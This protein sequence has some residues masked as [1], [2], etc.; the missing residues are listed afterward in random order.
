[1]ANPTPT[2]WQAATRL[3]L[4]SFL[5]VFAALTPAGAAEAGVVTGS[6]SN[7]VT[8]N[9]LEGA[10]VEIPKLGASALT[11]ATG[12]Y[13]L[14]GVP[15]GT[16]EVVASYIGLDP[17]RATVTVDAGR[18]ATR[19]FDLSSGVYQ[20]DTFKV[21]GEREGNA[22]AL[23]A[24]KNAPNVKNIVSID[25]Y[26][27]LPNMNA[28]EL[29]IL[30]P[31]VAGTVNDEGNYNGMNI[32][33][34]AAN[35]NTITVDGALL[36]SQGGSARA[37]RIHTITGSMFES[38]E[39]TKG[40]TPDKGA[41]SL[42]GTI[43]LKSRSP[44]NQKEKRRLT[45]NLSTRIA[46]SFTEQIPMRERHRA[47]P[48]LNAA[49]QE[50]F[51]VLGEER[52]LGVAVN[53]F[54]IEQAVGNFGTTRNFQTTSTQ[55][56]YLWDYGTEDNYNNRKQSSVNAKIDYRLSA[57]T[58][59]SLNTIYNDAFERFRLRY[60]FRAYTGSATAVPNATSGIVPGFTDRIT[61]VR[62]VAGSNV[63]ITSQ[64]SNFFHRQRHLDLNIEHKWGALEVDYGW[65]LSIDHI[66][67]GG[68]DGGVLVN[69]NIAPVG[70]ILDRTQSDLFP[71]LIQT[72]GPDLRLAASY[73]PNSY[74]F[75]DTKAIHEPREVRANV[76][77][78][79]PVAMKLSLKAGARVREEKVEDRSK[80]RRYNFTG[81]HAGQLP[82]DPSILTYGDL[83][84][85]LKIPA[86]SANAIARGRTPLDPVFWSEDRYFA[87]Q[88]KFTNTRGATETVTA[89][90][91]MAQGSIGRTG[92][93]TGV[94]TEKTDDES[95]GWVR[96]RVA[97][98]AAQQLADPVGSAQKDY[99][100]NRR[101]LKGSYT[102]S[103]PSVHLTQ[104]LMPNLKARL[105]WSNSFGRPPLSGFYP[106]ETANDTART[107][108]VPNPS[109]RPQTAENWD[110]TLEYYFEPVGNLSVGWFRKTIR[111]YFV[112]GIQ[113]GIVGTGGD[114]GYGGEYAGYTILTQA[115]LGTADIKGWE[116]SYLQQFTFLPGLLKGLSLSVNYTLLDTSGDFGGSVQRTTGQVPG[117]IPRSG[118]ISIG[119]RHRSF[120]ARVTANRVGDYIRN[121]TA[122]GSGANLYTEARTVVNAGVA[123]QWRPAVGFT[124]DVGNVF[125]EGQRW[126]RGIPDQMAQM[127]IPGT[128]VTVGVSG[129]F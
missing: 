37:T 24:Q 88:Q 9:L 111:D 21:T 121:F 73:K 42:G 2:P 77:Y 14:A 70:W 87:E 102:K 114:N 26:G 55:P 11:D 13:R 83:K 109:L 44:L 108:T 35:L 98:T 97:T 51:G 79:L 72:A 46:P 34:I 59:L 3:L 16:H 92:F 95:W 67:G 32:R 75:A 101:E 96:S 113:N 39:L 38:L 31:G 1:M 27:N 99:A 90:Y 28:S 4:A 47:H 122:V 76:K 25:A 64:M 123:Y 81:L 36:G 68:G 7:A 106:S 29:A 62:A 93:L 118:N 18:A 52:N 115:N 48:L 56:A 71:R 128:T 20:L 49:W 117:F 22:L 50:V 116:F 17:L 85:G 61:E 84:T 124:L 74:N 110:T 40:H 43:N 33:G 6:V 94:R 91:V 78:Q 103:F 105:S 125:N 119:W 65:A 63:D 8:R 89:G 54:Y 30:L 15:A 129:R 69:R 82:T 23:T 100:A 126:Y 58:K 5:S 127:Y 86:W 104:D 41:D 112:S 66:N 45:F 80:S 19:N 57:A 107:L 53:L 60:G 12:Q 10:R 120:S